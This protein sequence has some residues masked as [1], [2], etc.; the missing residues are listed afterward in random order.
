[1]SYEHMI[2]DVVKVFESKGF[3][4]NG[5]S[6]GSDGVNQAE[7]VNTNGDKFF[8]TYK[9][10]ITNSKGGAGGGFVD[11]NE[12]IAIGSSKGLIQMLV[13]KTTQE[14]LITIEKEVRALKKEI[15]DL[16]ESK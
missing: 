11:R 4:N 9:P 7:F 14:M 2:K 12:P 5:N 16:K 6:G 10:R 3:R 1:M 8:V 13:P 15:E